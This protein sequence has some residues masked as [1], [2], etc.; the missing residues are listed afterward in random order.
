[1]RKNNTNQN[2]PRG[3][4]NKGTNKMKKYKF[5]WQI[6]STVETWNPEFTP[7]H[8]EEKTFFANNYNE[9]KK[10]VE[11]YHK[12]QS[13]YYDKYKHIVLEIIREKTI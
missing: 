4:I 13:P 2:V 5:T 1:M 8:T 12:K 7:T 10:Q 11:E 3:T 6:K 9:A